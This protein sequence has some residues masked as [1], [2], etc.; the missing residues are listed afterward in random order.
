MKNGFVNIIAKGQ[1]CRK[2]N[3]S[4]KT[5]LTKSYKKARAPVV[6]KKGSA[7]FLGILVPSV[8]DLFFSLLDR[9]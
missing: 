5:G 6:I 9:Q 7:R 2:E 8:Q 1:K 4:Y 3:S